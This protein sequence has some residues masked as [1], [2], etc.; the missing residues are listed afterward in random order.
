MSNQAAV[1]EI[2]FQRLASFMKLPD[3]ARIVAA[4]Y[5]MQQPDRVRLMVVSPDLPPIHYG[6]VLP[7]VNPIYQVVTSTEAH[8][9]TTFLS[10]GI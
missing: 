3:S 1:I 4:E 6:C 9:E 5:Q 10:W 7:I 2:D 8:D